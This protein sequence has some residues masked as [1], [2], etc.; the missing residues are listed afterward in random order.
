MEAEEK[1]IELQNDLLLIEAYK[2]TKDLEKMQIFFQ[3]YMPMIYGICLKYLQNQEKSK[4]TVMDIYEKITVKLLSH[5]V[6][7]PKSWLYTLTKNHCYE[8]L[9]S[10][11]RVLEKET[12]AFNMYSAQVYRLSN[13][14]EKEQELSM[15]DHCIE[16]LEMLQQQV[17][18]L[19][20]LEK[21]S[22]KEICAEMSIKWDKARTLIQNGR[23]NLKLC[24]EKKYET[25]KEK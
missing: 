4:D 10:K 15:L 23:R 13:E 12:E 11:N 2:Q 18:R 21:K 17:I 1:N 5:E 6:K 7:N 14:E 9:R 24:M 19:F 20:Y 3:K 22:Y 16:N 25:I 8:I